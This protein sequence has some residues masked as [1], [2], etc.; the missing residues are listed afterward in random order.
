MMLSGE[1]RW[2]WKE[3]PPAGLL[4]WFIDEYIHGCR[5]GGGPPGRKDVYLVGND[6][7]ELSIKTRG[8]TGDEDDGRS[9]SSGC[10]DVEVKGLVDVDWEALNFTFLTGPLEFWGKWPF[11]SLDMTRTE[12]CELHKIRWLR[13]FDTSGAY[14]VEI[15]LGP[16]EKP[17]DGSMNNL[18]PTRGCNVEMT[19]IRVSKGEKW[20]SFCFE[21]FGDRRTIA[22]DLRAVATELNDRGAFPDFQS[23][24][25]LNYPRWI[26]TY[27]V[28]SQTNKRCK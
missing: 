8:G 22:D 26:S 20:F 4:E 25:C 28:S 14:P 17:V 11:P 15:P 24:I 9:T 18:L 16:D 1:I 3:R 21:A 6:L 23:G 19:E 10:N 7:G 13:K 12:K 5:P 2:F 27:V